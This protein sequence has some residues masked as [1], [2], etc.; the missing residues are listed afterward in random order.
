MTK[1]EKQNIINELKEIVMDIHRYAGDLD[2]EVQ[3]LEFETEI[4]DPDQTR[5]RMLV[6]GIIQHR[7]DCYKLKQFIEREEKIWS[8]LTK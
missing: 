3:I 7:K 5:W 2:N 6:A 8:K 4:D 1:E